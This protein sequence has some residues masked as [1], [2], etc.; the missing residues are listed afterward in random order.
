M[1]TK[2]KENVGWKRK[3][4]FHAYAFAFNSTEVGV[5]AAAAITTSVASDIDT[6]DLVKS[7]AKIAACYFVPAAPAYT[8]LKNV[9]KAV[10]AGKKVAFYGTKIYKITTIWTA[11]IEFVN[12]L[13]AKTLTKF[14]VN[15]AVKKACGV[16]ECDAFYW[17]RPEYANRT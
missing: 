4:A 17:E 5:W 7:G 12:S 11:P 8:I 9:D 1:A 13:G 3:V 14:G 10:Y 15:E 16:E 6:V 2:F